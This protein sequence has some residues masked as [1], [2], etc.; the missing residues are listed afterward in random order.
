MSE[1]LRERPSVAHSVPS[2][3]VK[4]W[5]EECAAALLCQLC[6]ACEVTAVMLTVC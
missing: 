1:G 5:L 2:Q 6:M 3:T 4:E